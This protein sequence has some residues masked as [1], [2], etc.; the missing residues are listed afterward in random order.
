MQK[1]QIPFSYYNYAKVTPTKINNKINEKPRTFG[2]IPF[3]YYNFSYVDTYFNGKL[4]TTGCNYKI[5]DK[6]QVINNGEPVFLFAKIKMNG[7]R[8]FTP[9]FGKSNN[10]KNTFL[11][12]L[13]LKYTNINL[14]AEEFRNSYQLLMNKSNII[15]DKDIF[16]N[17]NDVICYNEI[18]YRSIIVDDVFFAI[19]E[20]PTSKT[21]KLNYAIKRFNKES[22]SNKKTSI[23]TLNLISFT[24][25]GMLDIMNGKIIDK[26]NE[27]GIEAEN[28]IFVKVT[29]SLKNLL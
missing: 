7:K 19:N 16:G 5:N 11:S 8:I 22:R 29:Q 4:T 10:E 3:I 9:I 25:M 17:C 6:I 28:D 24:P 13:L 1:S 2:I 12:E 27:K 23:V 20:L 15:D 18:D 21:F 14:T 26:V